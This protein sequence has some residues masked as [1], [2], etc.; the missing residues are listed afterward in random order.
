MPLP[1]MGLVIPCYNEAARFDPKHLHALLAEPDLRVFLVDDGSSD[2]SG[3]LLADASAFDPARSRV[4]SLPRNLGKAEAVRRGLLALIDEGCD[5][6]GYADADFA[7]PPSEILRLFG[8]LESEGMKVVL[9]CR[10]ARLG[11]TIE[12][13]AARHYLGRVFA[14]GASIV[15]GVSVYDTQCGAKCYRVGPE[16]RGALA[17]PFVSRWIFD[18][19]LLGRLLIGARD[20][21]PIPAS[22]ILEVP[23]Q[24]WRDVPGSKLWGPAA[25]RAALD[26]IPVSRRLADRRR[27]MRPPRASQGPR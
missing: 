10:V 14:T 20:V 22:E 24:R 4:V 26:L 8:A 16:L 9:G 21:S 27:A 23:L 19:E 6:V 7:T 5:A 2:A 1:S 17:E 3:S 12:R 25:L 13:R 18:V 15:L 11:A